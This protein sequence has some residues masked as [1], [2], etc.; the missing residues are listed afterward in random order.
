MFTVV[1]YYTADTPYEEEA[2]K[3]VRTLTSVGIASYQV[4]PIVNLGTWLKNVAY[5]ITFV[6]EKLK[7]LDHP[8]VWADVDARFLEY[9]ALFNDLSCD[10]AFH[11]RHG[12]ELLAGTIY[13]EPTEPTFRLLE[14]W[15]RKTK[16]GAGV[17]QH[18]LAHMLQDKERWEDVHIGHLPVEYCAIFDGDDRPL[19]PVILHT[20]VSRKLRT[21]IDRGQ[22][23]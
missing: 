1:S 13:A 15:E 14:E 20:Q 12:T 21:P 19:H 16:G 6:K 11:Y 8:V 7:E 10:I 2:W 18:I 5:K 22:F 9:P 23:N 17:D 4:V 3:F